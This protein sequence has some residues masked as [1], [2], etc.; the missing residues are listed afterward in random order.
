MKKIYYQGNPDVK[1]LDEWFRN[2]NI[3]EDFALSE[4]GYGV[5]I[6]DSDDIVK[7]IF[8]N[9]NGNKTYYNDHQLVGEYKYP[10]NHVNNR[11]C[12]LLISEDGNSFL[13]GKEPKNF[14]IPKIPEGKLHYMGCLSSNDEAFN[15]LPFDVH[16]I[17]PKF[18][19]F[20]YYKLDY[21]NPYKP[22]LVNLE[23][24]KQSVWTDDLSLVNTIEVEFEKKHFVAKNSKNLQTAYDRI[25][26]NNPAIG[27][28]GIPISSVLDD[29]IFNERFICQLYP[30]ELK[31]ILTLP[32]EHEEKRK[33]YE[34]KY[35]YGELF[36]YID[37]KTNTVEYSH[38][39]T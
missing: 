7:E 1:N 13:G 22:E 17:V 34:N 27:H 25:M 37:L 3:N 38:E 29:Q 36:V 12:D 39:S 23:E 21:S 28:T 10:K 18:M 16:L 19:N 24:F 11:V 33:W 26:S 6:F 35:V 2:Y 30:K 9:D 32:K 4:G 5:F 31:T 14:S 8:T 20:D 15:W